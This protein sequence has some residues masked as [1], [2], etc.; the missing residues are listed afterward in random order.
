[1][2]PG[3]TFLGE[4]I[5][6][7][8]HL[9]VVL[10]N[11]SDSG[12]FVVLTMI[13]TYD[14]DYKNDACVLRQSDGHPF[15]KHLSY[16]AYEK[17]VLYPVAKLELLEKNGEIKPMPSFSPETLAKILKGADSISSRLRDDCWLVLDNQGLLPK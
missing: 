4:V 2:K 1:M 13:S 7:G 12:K 15:I 3:N 9:H 14:E 6:I 11:P 10:S 8:K 16:V 17:A 5:G